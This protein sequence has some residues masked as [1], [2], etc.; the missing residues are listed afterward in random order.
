M[1]LALVVLVLVAA[2][3]VNFDDITDRE[4][5]NGPHDE[6]GDGIDDFLDNCPHVAGDASDVDG[7]G[8]GDWC[9]PEP[10]NPR[11]RWTLFDP[12]ISG[13][14]FSIVSGAWDETGD[15]LHYGSISG[16]GQLR[17]EL[18]FEHGVLEIAADIVS[19]D[20]ETTQH[21][22]TL[23]ILESPTQ[24]YYYVE[25]YDP[26]GMGY[27]AVSKFNGAQ[28]TPVAQVGLVGGVDPGVLRLQLAVS[29]PNPRLHVLAEWPDERY[30]TNTNAAD[31]TGGTR[32]DVGVKGVVL[33]LRYI[34]VIATN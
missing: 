22:V 2:C 19:R 9:D 4:G 20:A 29:P 26:G 18:V 6:D 15:A 30:T 28:F 5:D 24:P 27:A 3:R 12:L 25:A 33:E 31:Y 17:R 21:Q 13:S 1:R 8:V 14:G 23:A 7:D 32:L 34:A 11:Q 10:T 16:F